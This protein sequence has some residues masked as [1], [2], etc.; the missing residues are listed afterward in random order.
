MNMNSRLLALSLLF[1]VSLT[2]GCTQLGGTQTGVDSSLRA[3]EQIE[4]PLAALRENFERRNLARFARGIHPDYRDSKSQLR[5]DLANVY[6]VYSSIELDIYGERVT[7]SDNTISVRASWNL[8]W[9]C[10]GP[11]SQ[12]PSS[13]RNPSDVGTT[14][15]RKGET[16][17][18]FR[19]HK[20]EWLLVNQENA[21]L[22]GSL[23]PG[24]IQ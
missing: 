24:T 2:L 4:K 22:F 13:C 9:T 15:L 23:A 16:M 7:R 11:S 10:Q 12:A 21:R 5:N 6:R 8:R 3:D 14:I 20:D 18:E 17:F 1:M 19:R